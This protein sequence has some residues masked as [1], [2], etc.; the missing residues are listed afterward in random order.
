MASLTAALL[1][2]ALPRQIPLAK[3]EFSSLVAQD[4]EFPGLPD[5]S[6]EPAKATEASVTTLPSGL[7][8]VT[9]GACSTSTVSITY[10]KAG[11]GEEALDEAGAAHINKC[12]GFKSGSDMSTLYIM[13]TME[14]AGGVPF[15][16][17]DRYSA[18][19][20]YT[21]NRETATSILGMLAVDSSFELWDVRDAKKHASLEAEEASTSAQIML[22]ENLF[23]AAYGPQTSA[24]RS[25]FMSTP[26]SS[27]LIKSFR[28][29]AY[30]MNGAVLTATG[31]SDHTAFCA[32]VSET[33][34]DSPAGTADKSDAFT[35]IGGESR[36]SAP[37]AGYAHVALA[38][39]STA[40]SAV[41]N[42][43]KQA[44]SIAGMEAGVEA[45][46][47]KGLVGLYAGSE[48]GAGLV[49]SMMNTLGAVTPD[50]I[51][52]AKTLAKFEALMALD[53]GS[54]TLAETMT[55]SV[56]ESGSFSGPAAIAKEYDGIADSAV[57]SELSAMV[58][59]KPSLAAIGDIGLV[60]YHA[61]IKL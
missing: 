14:M 49:D 16:K 13:R 57:S 11:S 54:Q 43:L 23:A 34:K 42:V 39:E 41:A 19:L 51:K 29:R 53:G 37:S 20:G 31:V 36:V 18:T 44:L 26:P 15:T 28:A 1:K 60:P 48:D 4:L 8:V 52:R 50:V 47:T 7:T 9:E 38:F 24:G 33:L 58:K 55:A 17:A 32:E 22:T 12:M 6:P 25:F 56:L 21:A 5:V 40:T 3:K 45:F 61:D 2:K 27:D 46:A 59:K 10:P 35:Y 30:G